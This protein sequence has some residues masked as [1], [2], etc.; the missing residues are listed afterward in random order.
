MGHWNSCE[1]DLGKLFDSEAE[2]CRAHGVNP[3][4]YNKRKQ[5]G[6]PIKHCL[7]QPKKRA[8]TYKGQSYKS[9][10]DCCLRKNVSYGNVY[11]NVT[12]RGYTISE[13]IDKELE[14]KDR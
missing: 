2:M 14:R 3:N 6:L 1:D 5:N 7:A 13:A 11:K 9:L 12:Y 10:R 4:T 8:I